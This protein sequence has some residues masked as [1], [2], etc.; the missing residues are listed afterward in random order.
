MS[1]YPAPP[2]SL[3][4]AAARRALWRY[5]G[6][7][8]L[9]GLTDVVRHNA[10]RLL[11]TE[12][13]SALGG[14]LGRRH[15][16]RR[17][18]TPAIIQAFLA[19]IRT[20]SSAA[21]RAAMEVALWDHLGRTLAEFSVLER[22]WPEGRIAVEGAEHIAAVR[23]AG[24][25]LILAGMHVGNWEALHA[26]LTGMGLPLAVIYQRLPNR[27]QMAVADR[28]RRRTPIRLLDPVPESAL[29]ARRL[30]ESRERA[31]LMFIDEHVRRRVHAPLL[32]RS[33]RPEG[34]IH[35]LARLAGLTGAAVL[36]VHALR[37]GPAARFRLVIGAE[38][39][40]LRQPRDAAA[41]AADQAMLDAAAEAVVRAHP[42]QWLMATCFSWDG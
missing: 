5:W 26:G 36:P 42:E 16:R 27:F 38:L 19:R 39:P 11:P 20:E 22:L 28:A 17:S 32:G 15:G 7:D 35:R 9:F 40:L 37:V 18:G 33:P 8:L 31:L 21:E 13:C 6:R 1:L 41:V 29:V 10:L 34:N 25:P 2:F 3:A 23:A 24:R 12:R 14:A 30:L 4:D